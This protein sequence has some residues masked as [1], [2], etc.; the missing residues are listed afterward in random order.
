MEFNLLKTVYYLLL[1]CICIQLQTIVFAKEGVYINVNKTTDIWYLTYSTDTFV[2]RIAFISNPNDSRSKR[3]KPISN[4][5]EVVYDKHQEFIQKKDGKAF[6]LV[7]LRLT[8]TYT[9]L[10]KAYAPFAPFSDGGALIHTG[11]LFACINLCADE[12]NGWQLTI[13]VEDNTHII[14]S[15]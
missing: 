14:V 2:N 13:D 1:S 6:N 7:Q 15:G 9:Q 3:W 4:E 8:P 12:A 5:F 11:R 10:P